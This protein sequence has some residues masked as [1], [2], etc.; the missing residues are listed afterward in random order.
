MTKKTVKNSSVG[1]KSYDDFF[2]LSRFR[3]DIGLT[4]V[5]NKKQIAEVSFKSIV[6]SC[7][8]LIGET[9]AMIPFILKKNGSDVSNRDK[10]YRL[11]Q[12]PN[13]LM[14]W[15]SFI[16]LYVVMRELFGEVYIYLA[17]NRL[18][19]VGQLWIIPSCFINPV[20]DKDNVTIKGYSF[21]FSEKDKIDFLPD[22]IVY[23]FI[24]KPTSFNRGEGIVKKVD[25][26][27]D[28]H[29]FSKKYL[30]N[31]FKNGGIPAGILKTD[32]QLSPKQIADIE[33]QWRSK[34]GSS[35]DNSYKLAILWGGLSYDR[36]SINPESDVFISQSKWTKDDIC[37]A[38]RVPTSLLYSEGVNKNTAEQQEKTFLKYCIYPKLVKISSLFT[39]KIIPKLN[40]TQSYWFGY[41]NPVPEDETL[42]VEKAKVIGLYGLG[43]INEMRALLGLDPL[44]D[45]ALGNR[46]VEPL[47]L[48]QGRQIETEGSEN[49]S[50]GIVEETT[51]NSDKE[52][53]DILQEIKSLLGSLNG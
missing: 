26:E 34:F 37:A 25:I 27:Y 42:K 19:Q 23:D 50:N 48:P 6:F 43:T 9:I 3:G 49:S 18:G 39:N 24:P 53:K 31:F 47:N 30:K 29:V 20:F 41:A 33:E 21:V 10:L 5:T 12:N 16:Y 14:D 11:L 1:M 36:I 4:D 15:F 28:I 45:D 46:L 7:V 8:N 35:T 2:N 40:L 38:F 51:S 17:K 52:Y 32:K 22:E 44:K 13:P